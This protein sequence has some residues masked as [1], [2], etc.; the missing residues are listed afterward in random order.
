MHPEEDL[1]QLLDEH[2]LR[3][4][5]PA[6]SHD[7]IAVCLAAAE[8]LVQLRKFAPPPQFTHRLEKK[9]RTIA[10]ARRGSQPIETGRLI[11]FPSSPG[12]LSQLPRP[13]QRH[14]WVVTFSVVAVLLIAVTSFLA[15]SEQNNLPSGWKQAQ[16]Q[17]PLTARAGAQNA[18]NTALEHLHSALA[19]LT[20]VVNAGQDDRAIQ[21]ALETVSL[22]TRT[23]GSAV[24]AL[25]AG[26]ALQTTQR[27]LN[28]VLAEED[29]TLR[30]LLVRV[31]W[32]MKVAFT[33]QLGRLGDPVLR[34][35]H[36]TVRAQ[37][38]GTFL[39]TI[40][41]ANFASRAQLM[42]IGKPTGTVIQRSTSLL[43]A[44]VSSAQ[45]FLEPD[46]IGVFNPDGTA[47]QVDD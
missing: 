18:A 20:T 5:Q 12:A 8:R 11:P 19:D 10:R 33:R 3:E 2:L 34:V 4:N 45:R 44:V 29:Q 26:P 32:P 36:V 40:T 31:D 15:L 47:A 16:N 41:G 1:Y 37:T 28:E 24:S 42:I 46:T 30:L 14:A 13:R 21:Q 6:S 27:R 43:V 7:E 25:S 23:S 39:V 35:F 17:G 9:I 22:W 38:A